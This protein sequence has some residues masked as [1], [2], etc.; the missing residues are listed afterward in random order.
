MKPGVERSCKGTGS[1]ARL[2]SMSWMALSTLSRSS[3]LRLEV[4]FLGGDSGRVGGG[5]E[6]RSRKPS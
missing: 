6:K 3:G 2:A 5:V 4:S 1:I